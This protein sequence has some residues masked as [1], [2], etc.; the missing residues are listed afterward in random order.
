MDILVLGVVARVAAGSH[1]REP[2]FVFL[3]SG[4]VVLLLS[5][6]F[7]GLRLLDGGYAPGRRILGT[8]WAVYYTLLG[9]SALHPSMRQLSEPGPEPDGGLTRARLVLLACASFTVPLLI[10]VRSALN[11]QLDVYVLVG[12]SALMFALVLMRMAGIM[13]RNEEVTARGGWSR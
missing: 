7:Y 13:R 9:T 1:R 8:G 2:A 10:V 12:A 4:T 5:D 6:A 3:L 11:E